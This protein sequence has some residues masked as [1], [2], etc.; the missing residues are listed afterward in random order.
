MKNH[1]DVTHGPL[2][3]R[4]VANTADSEFGSLPPGDWR[5]RR[6]SCQHA[7]SH[8]G[9]FEGCNQMAADE[10]AT[11]G[12]QRLPDQLPGW[13]CRPASLARPCRHRAPRT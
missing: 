13:L 1:I 9:V 11:P 5:R 7:N 2:Q 12:H 8:S 6:G 4:A 3:G 10:S